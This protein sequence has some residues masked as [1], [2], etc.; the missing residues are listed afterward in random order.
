LVCLLHVG[1]S[2]A[3]APLP[4]PVRGADGRFVAAVESA[5]RFG[6]ASQYPSGYRAGVVNSVLEEN[7]IKSGPNA[8]KVR[9]ADGEIVSRS[10]PRITVEH[11]LA[12][13][14]HWN[15]IGYNSSR[16][17]RNDFFND[18][19]NMS[20]R[21]QSSNSSDGGLMSSRG[22]RYRQDVGP[23]YSR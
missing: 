4:G 2:D 12:V 1:N 21:L 22:I 7:T 8:G 23:E 13:V 15:T 10:D 11:N 14:T 19:T 16:A 9:M 17:V 6:R 5:T 18:T 3:A 20:L